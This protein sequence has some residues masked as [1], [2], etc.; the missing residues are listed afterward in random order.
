[1]YLESPSNSVFVLTVPAVQ[2]EPVF[3]EPAPDPPYPIGFP[4]P[5][6][7]ADSGG[8]TAITVQ[9]VQLVRVAPGPALD[10]LVAH[11]YTTS[12]TPTG[13]RPT[14]AAFWNR[15]VLHLEQTGCGLP[16]W[17][18]GGLQPSNIHDGIGSG[19]VPDYDPRGGSRDAGFT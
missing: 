17:C 19:W 4:S 6:T 10:H 8:P 11:N 13:S 12:N 16:T 15:S 7:F 2:W 1:M 9:S 18:H 14:D 5:L 3:T